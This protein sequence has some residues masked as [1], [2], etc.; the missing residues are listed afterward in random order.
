M[1]SIPGYELKDYV[2]WQHDLIVDGN[3]GANPSLQIAEALNIAT[4]RI[5]ITAEQFAPILAMYE[6]HRELI[7]HA[8]HEFDED[9]QSWRDYAGYAFD[10]VPET[11]GDETQ[12]LRDALTPNV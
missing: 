9:N 7:E 11:V 10:G 2:M 8:L 4:R 1:S 5:R 3:T 6:P 12:R